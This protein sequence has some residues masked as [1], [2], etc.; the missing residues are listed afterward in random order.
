MECTS[1]KDTG[2]E[3]SFPKEKKVN[4]QEN[5]VLPCAGFPGSKCHRTSL[6]YRIIIRP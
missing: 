6:N 1:V 4:N 3:R 5:G 2:I